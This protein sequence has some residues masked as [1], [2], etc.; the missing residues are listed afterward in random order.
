ME[1]SKAFLRVSR[2]SIAT[3]SNIIGSHTIFLRKGDGTPKARITW[4]HRDSERDSIR[5]DSPCVHIEI[6][7]LVLSLAAEQSW[8]LV[9]MDIRTAFLQARGFDRLLYVI[10]PKEEDDGGGLWQ[11]LAATNGL[12]DSGRL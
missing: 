7:R 9:Q 8:A 12:V 10:P 1:K 11:L 2:S 4:G 6:F 5:S 3:V